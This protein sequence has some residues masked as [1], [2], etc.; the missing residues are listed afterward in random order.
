MSRLLSLSVLTSISPILVA[1]AATGTATGQVTSASGAAPSSFA[2][3]VR[4]VSPAVVSID[5][6]RPG[7]DPVP[8]IQETPQGTVAG[9][10]TPV[11]MGAGSGFFITADGYVVTNNHV[12]DGAREITVSMGDGRQFPARLVGRDAPTDLAVLKVAASGVPFVSFSSAAQP[13]VGD[14]VVAVGNPFGL[15]GTAT[16]G[17]VSAQ[18]REIGE[19]HVGFLQ[20]DAPINSG[21]SGGPS[22]DLQ[23][24]VVGVNTAI[25]SPSGAFVGI[26]LAVPA[27]LANEITQ[28]LIRSGRVVRG[29]LGVGVQGLTPA[30]A[31]RMNLRGQRGAVISTVSPTGPAAGA[32]RP[33][34]VVV[35]VNGTEVEGAGTLTRAIASARPGT[36]LD[37]RV[38]RGGQ[39]SDVT[40]VAAQR[41]DGT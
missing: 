2:P 8:W 11:R 7:G 29:Y 3:I 18:G 33:G 35:A 32:L 5:T 13:D 22:F 26:G 41:P 12:I 14:W 25:I 23:G 39:T 27:D 16:A 38:L 10:A 37:L 6:V 21:N 31:A 19:A 20:I 40:V 17:I 1:C 28:E 4:R 30:L 34:D 36:R 24:H 15:G 9:L